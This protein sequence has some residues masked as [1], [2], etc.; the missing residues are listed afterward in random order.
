MMLQ[1]EAAFCL[2]FS[3]GGSNAL[4]ISDNT[5]PVDVI[6]VSVLSRYFVLSPI[7]PWLWS[8]PPPMVTRDSPCTQNQQSK[9]S[10]ALKVYS[11][12]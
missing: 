10:C 9:K 8:P 3:Y 5:D 4:G 1:R 6:S 2:V 12:S 7:R 11:Y